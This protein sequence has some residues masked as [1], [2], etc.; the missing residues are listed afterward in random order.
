MDADRRIPKD[1]PDSTEVLFWRGPAGYSSL[2]TETII[3][4]ALR[5]RGFGIRFVIC[6]GALSGCIRRSI[7]DETPI[8][9]WS[10]LCQHCVDYAVR[11]LK[12][13]GLPYVG[14]SEVVAPDQRAEF[15]R[16]CN[17]LSTEYLASYEY[18][19]VPVGRFAKLSALRYL[20]GEPLEE[21]GDVFRE[22]LFS[23]LI[24][25]EAARNALNNLKPRQ[26]FMQRHLEYV[27]W[28]PAYVVLTKAGLPTTLWGGS[29]TQDPRITL[30]NTVGMDCRPV[31]DMADEA[32]E[33]R[34]KQPLKKAQ[35]E[36]LDAVLRNPRSPSRRPTDPPR[37]LERSKSDFLSRETLLRELGISDARPIWCV[38]THVTWDAGFNPEVMVFEDVWDWVSTT[39]RAMLDTKSVTWLLKAHPGEYRGTR[40]GLEE[41]V[42]DRF[43]GVAE[44]IHFIPADSTITTNDL[45]LILSGGITMRGTVGI[46]LTARGIPVIVGEEAHYAGKGYTHDGFTRERYLELVHQAGDITFLS[47]HQRELARRYA[48]ASYFQRAIPIN[49]AE[50]RG[51]Y[52]PLDPK[53]FGLLLPGNDVAMDMICDRIIN[54]GE[55]ILDHEL[56]LTI[57]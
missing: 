45:S 38:F 28:A 17:D 7:Q 26:L 27:G 47:E 49:M 1:L 23:A 14:M 35:K 42:K 34:S 3:A 29:I 57:W 50:G 44:H 20:R 19:D 21:H 52:T 10:N 6:D 31:Y 5:L 11:V 13:S 39:V 22:Y 55:F 56:A 12:A 36:A 53:R 37:E 18:C 30:R 24:C 32:W 9:Q 2:D 33:R 25:A 41:F 8:S 43:P 46:E 51:A 40:Y 16:I 48:Y 15:R 54:G 4:L